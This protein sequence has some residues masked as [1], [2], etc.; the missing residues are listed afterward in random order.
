MCAPFHPES[1]SYARIRG[2]QT[3]PYLFSLSLSLLGQRA[4]WHLCNDRMRATESI[5]D[6]LRRVL[7]GK[8][9]V[10]VHTMRARQTER[11]RGC[12][13]VQE[14]TRVSA[15]SRRRIDL[16]SSRIN[17]RVCPRAYALPTP[18]PI[19]RNTRTARGDWKKGGGGVCDWLFGSRQGKILPRNSVCVYCW[20]I[21]SPHNL[22]W[23]RYC[24]LGPLSL[25]SIQIFA[26]KCV[27]D[28]SPPS[29]G[30]LSIVVFS[31]RIFSILYH[32]ASKDIRRLN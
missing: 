2:A 21:F 6:R 3:S 24:R 32:G 1:G 26:Q 28:I 15:N 10:Y 12:V 22:F 11:E 23:R 5:F 18:L 16:D 31:K 17:C 20:R 4:S 14:S 27:K 29:F 7:A 13:R 30:S 25:A 9:C 19:C 8:S